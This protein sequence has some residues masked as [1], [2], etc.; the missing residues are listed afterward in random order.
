MYVKATGD[1]DVVHNIWD[2]TGGKPTIIFAITNLNDTLNIEWDNASYT[3]KNITFSDTPKYT[4][5]VVIDK[6]FDVVNCYLW[7]LQL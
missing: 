5:A 3:P 2:F 7:K 1:V 6:V 4:F